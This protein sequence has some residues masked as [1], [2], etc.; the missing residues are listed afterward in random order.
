MLVTF[1]EIVKIFSISSKVTLDINNGYQPSNE[2]KTAC[3]SELTLWSRNV[4][5]A[6]FCSSVIHT[7]G[8]KSKE[9]WKLIIMSPSLPKA[10]QKCICIEYNRGWYTVGRLSVSSLGSMWRNSFQSVLA[11]HLGLDMTK[12]CFGIPNTLRSDF[13]QKWKMGLNSMSESLTEN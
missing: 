6:Y 8:Q 11:S 10:D 13:A 2:F 4:F 5:K 9:R 1:T 12:W 7:A 3:R